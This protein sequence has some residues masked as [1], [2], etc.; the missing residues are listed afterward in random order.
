MQ[1]TSPRQFG[2]VL[3]K[4]SLIYLTILVSSTSRFQEGTAVLV[5]RTKFLQEPSIVPYE[6]TY[7]VWYGQQ[8]FHMG[9]EIPFCHTKPRHPTHQ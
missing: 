9:T 6:N 7:N 4:N 1:P 3:E 8:Y 5:G 2:L